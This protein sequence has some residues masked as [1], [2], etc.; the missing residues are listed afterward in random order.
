MR[1]QWLG[2]PPLGR[3]DSGARLGGDG[4]RLRESVA[5]SLQVR[6]RQL[7]GAELVLG[8]PG[9][10][11]RC[12]R[13]GRWPP[14]QMI[15]CSCRVEHWKNTSR[16]CHTGGAGPEG[17][18]GD[19]LGIQW[20]S[21]RKVAGSGAPGTPK[22]LQKM[23]DPPTPNSPFINLK[24]QRCVFKARAGPGQAERDPLLEF[25]DRHA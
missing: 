6:E 15:V 8:V 16:P 23:G 19:P 5:G 25:Y 20:G 3:H 21:V 13:E 7:L 22:S 12:P 18:S 14:G 24:D 2:S 17:S 11:A 1:R 4:C 9:P 10:R